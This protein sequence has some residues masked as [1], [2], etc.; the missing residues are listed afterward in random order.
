[1]QRQ[2][3]FKRWFP[4]KANNFQLHFTFQ[5]FHLLCITAVELHFLCDHRNET[6]FKIWFTEDRTHEPCY[7]SE[8]NIRHTTQ[9]SL[10]FCFR[11]SKFLNLSCKYV[12]NWVYINSDFWYHWPSIYLE[13][14]F[15]HASGEDKQKVLNEILKSQL[16]HTRAHF[17]SFDRV[18]TEAYN[19]LNFLIPSS[20]PLQLSFILFAIVEVE[21]VLKILISVH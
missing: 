6:V 21:T 5:K 13:F 4:S 20:M 18:S 10:I 17:N 16:L 12:A 7:L 8:A 19:R 3:Q 1:M 14:W 11:L 15:C 2:A 9:F